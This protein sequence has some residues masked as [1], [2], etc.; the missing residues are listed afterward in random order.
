[1][2][3]GKVYT[4][5]TTAIEQALDDDIFSDDDVDRL[6]K[7][8]PKELHT[9]DL[10]D[11]F[12]LKHVHTAAMSAALNAD[13]NRLML[14][15]RPMN[16]KTAVKASV[17]PVE[18]KDVLIDKRFKLTDRQKEAVTLLG[19]AATHVLLAGGSRS[20][21][22][23]ITLRAL[24][25][26]ALASPGSR[27]V[28]LR[29]RFNHAKTTIIDDTFPKMMALCFPGQEY[30]LDKTWW[31]YEFPNGAQIWVGGLDDK[32]RTEKIL[33]QEYATIFLNES[34]Q[35]M[36][37]AVGTALTRL[38]QNCTY[39]VMRQTQEGVQAPMTMPLRLK[40]FYDC[41]PPKQSHWLYDLFVRKRDPITKK[42]IPTADDYAM[43]YMNPG[44]NKAN[45]PPAY[46]KQLESLPPHLKERF[47]YG[48]FGSNDDSALFSF[49]T[50][51]R[52]RA[53]SE[54]LPDMQRIIVAIDPSGS[55]DKDNMHNDAIGIVVVGLGIDG[56][57]YLLEDLTC[58]AGPKV[59]GNIAVTAFDRWEAD[60]IVGETNYG[61][62][63]VR[64]VVQTA[65][66][67][68]PFM[69]VTAS[70][71]KVVRAEPI[72]ALVEQGK[73]RHAGTFTELEEELCGFTTNG[74]VGSG[75]PNRGDA[76]VWAFAALFPGIVKEKQAKKPKNFDTG[77]RGPQGWMGA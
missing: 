38:A 57:G 3:R 5:L 43:M 15:Q 73:V 16:L 31:F 74:Y 2:G 63:M 75:S 23:F 62:D 68:V 11:I 50:F 12:P 20:G 46:L 52:W 72:S 42:P 8:L 51:E 54:N 19:S 25:I 7:G 28:V 29:F 41:N 22:T 47:L 58:K 77:R 39:Q 24:A 49:E 48:K 76:Y 33:G 69:K 10:D 56:V 27:H 32:E 14:D 18:N 30:R 17:E 4:G 44:D 71:G 45:L 65:K 35:I 36:F 37:E 13:P 64:Y 6:V 34:S 70:R 67:K 53:G 61:G 40:M 55:G 21:K 1:M 60:L 66:P 26:R 59:W 9:D